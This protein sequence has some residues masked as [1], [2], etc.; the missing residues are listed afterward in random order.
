MMCEHNKWAI[1]E[2]STRLLFQ[3]R[4]KASNFYLTI[5]NAERCQYDALKRCLEQRFD[6]QDPPSVVRSQL[7]SIKQNKDENL[8]EFAE[9]V[10][11][12]VSKGNADVS[13]VQT[14]QYAVEFFLK[15]ANNKTIAVKILD[16]NTVNYQMVWVRCER[17]STTIKLFLVVRRQVQV[18][19]GVIFQL[20][21]VARRA[22]MMGCLELV[23][24]TN[25]LKLKQNVRCQ[26]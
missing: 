17:L 20:G 26:T 19:N 18:F 6:I 23:R 5:P 12:L 4:G 8:E 13:Q 3:L 11:K 16:T 2:K 24:L 22:L 7:S 15:G 14:E 1:S 25:R 10:Q 21:P 9:R